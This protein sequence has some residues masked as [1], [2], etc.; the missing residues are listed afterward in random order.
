MTVTNDGNGTATVSSAT[1]T[2]GDS[3]TFTA[4]PNTNYVFSG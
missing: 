4:T 2:A 1:V 3:V